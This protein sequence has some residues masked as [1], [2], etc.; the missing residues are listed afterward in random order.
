M[1]GLGFTANLDGYIDVD[2]DLQRHVYGR[3]ERRIAGWQAERD[4]LAAGGVADY[5][6]QV[7]A[8]VLAGIGDLP[9][10]PAGPPPVEWLGEV[11]HPRQAR[12]RID[13]LMLET[14]PGTRVPAT[15]Y[16]PAAALTAPSGSVPAVLFVCGHGPLGKAYPR[17][18][19]VCT[20]LAAAGLVVLVLDPVGQGERFGYLDADGNAL[21]ADGTVEHTYSGLQ[22][23]WAGWSPARYFVTDARRGLDLLESLPVVDPARLAITGN[24]GGGTLCSLMMALEPRLAAAAPGT[25]I[26]SRGH[27]LWSGQRQDA[28]Q[29]LLGGT[30]AGVDHDD[31]LASMAP[32]PVQ[33]LAVD[34]DFFPIEGTIASVDRA[35]RIYGLLGAEQELRLARAR[36]THEYAPALARAAVDF[37]TEVFDLPPAEPVQ[38]DDDQA[39]DPRLLWCTTS[40]QTALDHP[41]TRFPHDLVRAEYL[42]RISATAQP[43]ADD[44]RRWVAERVRAQREVPACPRARWLPGP[45]GAEHAFWRSE[46]DLWAAGVLLP[47]PPTGAGAQ[48]RATGPR[49]DPVQAPATTPALTLLL[50]HGGTDALTD[51]HPEVL[52]RAA[53]AH[54][55]GP[56]VALDVRGTG[57]LTPRDRDGR[58]WTDQSGTSYKLL[59]DL[60]WLDD[61]LAAGRAFDVIRAIDVLTSDPHLQERYPGL[62]PE[63]EIHLVGAGVGAQVATLAAVSDPRVA[64]IAVTDLVDTDRV[65]T[66]RLHDRGTGAWQG[67]IPGMALWAST[68][69]LRELLGTRLRERATP[70]AE[71]A[72]TGT[73]GRPA[74]PD[75]IRERPGGPT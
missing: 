24:S 3:T 52:A 55:E 65:L 25:Y 58:A 41:D 75:P 28:E 60:L 7:R 49:H 43:A 31:L 21:V 11:R 54:A 22:S 4:H 42:D 15:L 46:V 44:I 18:Q 30:A 8:A 62:G 12:A 37:F 69:M 32:R 64:T 68:R 6:E 56:A 16:R 14:L 72:S 19:S 71:A 51:D 13:R 48:A 70:T 5:Q 63:S 23:W 47:D 53:G 36:S 57:A 17:Y 39:L 33:V 66:E 45:A 40:G 27:Y 35:R 38:L 61:S 10:S 2:T 9:D 74:A 73:H 1:V 20:Q 34:Y 59:C 67:L 50:L 29:I 26:T